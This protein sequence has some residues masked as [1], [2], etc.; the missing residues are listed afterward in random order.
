MPLLRHTA[1]RYWQELQPIL[2][3]L[4][5]RVSQPCLHSFQVALKEPRAVLDKAS[6]GRIESFD[7][8]VRQVDGALRRGKLVRNDGIKELI[9]AAAVFKTLQLASLQGLVL[10]IAAAGRQPGAAAH[11]A[12]A[13]SA[14]SLFQLVSEACS[15]EPWASEA[16]AWRALE[17][18]DFAD[19][20]CH[21]Q[22]TLRLA[23]VAAGNGS[24]FFRALNIII[25]C[26]LALNINTGNLI[27]VASEGLSTCRADADRGS[28]ALALQCLV[29]AYEG[30]GQ[31]SEALQPSRARLELQ[32]GGSGFDAEPLSHAL[33]LHALLL[34][35]AGRDEEAMSTS[36]E[37]SCHFVAKGI[38][39]SLLHVKRGE[40][41]RA[42][43]AVAEMV[44]EAG[45]GRDETWT[46]LAFMA[47]GHL[48]NALGDSL[49]AL[50][51][52]HKA[53]WAFQATL[54]SKGLALA[55]L[56]A[57]QIYVT[58]KPQRAIRAAQKAEDILAGT[59][60]RSFSAAR[61]IQASILLR[62][63]QPREACRILAEAKLIRTSGTDGSGAA[64]RWSAQ[65][66]ARA[67]LETLLQEFS[68]RAV[69]RTRTHA[70]KE[71]DYTVELKYCRAQ[72]PSS[73][74]ENY[75]SDLTELKNFR[76]DAK[77]CL[78]LAY[79]AFQLS[80][81][82]LE[83][84]PRHA[85]DVFA[86]TEL[87]IAGFHCLARALV[88]AERPQ[89]ALQMIDEAL[90]AL[91][92]EAEESRDIKRLQAWSHIYRSEISAQLRKS[93]PRMM[94]A[95]VADAERSKSLFQELGD[96]EAGAYGLAVLEH[97]VSLASAGE[98]REPRT[99]QK[100]S[101]RST[102]SLRLASDLPPPDPPPPLARD[103]LVVLDIIR[104]ELCQLLGSGEDV[105]NDTPLIDAGLDS[106]GSIELRNQMAKRFSVQLPSTVV[107]DYPS[108]KTLSFR[109]ADE[110]ALHID[111]HF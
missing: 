44:E 20:L 25:L 37:M 62:L 77:K 31:L 79:E 9:E 26:H 8:A 61:N 99:E 14:P 11:G 48:E 54:N 59:F 66:L 1:S 84:G 15:S 40:G 71:L 58:L 105:D 81:E 41:L 12:M 102:A 45:Q 46:A 90:E 28:E 30:A 47:A 51:Y 110:S 5:T 33:G 87:R 3:D 16:T 104:E 98:S 27:E 83:T 19:A 86:D 42:K 56:A 57:A 17:R 32:R 94:E 106:L 92:G 38:V 63:G 23:T 34:L 39:L 109:I 101:S 43:A 82:C 68:E 36:E 2:Q 65:L 80:K 74:E 95:A 72:D 64:R 60:P 103:P 18:E 24:H 88:V 107:F 29:Q 85:L 55:H 52:V 7:A 49:A 78:T 73:E 13:L 70:E 93:Q 97:L 4:Q 76:A 21:A 96:S 100:Q 108:I 67:Q 75:F 91:E 89:E 69:A 6:D 53:I 35:K 50:D 10:L 111:R 22:Q